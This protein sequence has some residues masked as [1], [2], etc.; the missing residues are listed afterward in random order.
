MDERIFV[1]KTFRKP[2]HAVVAV[3]NKDRV[4]MKDLLLPFP[5][6]FKRYAAVERAA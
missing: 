6:T 5:A 4:L 2:Y 1:P 3:G